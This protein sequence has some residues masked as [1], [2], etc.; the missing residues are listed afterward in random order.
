[1]SQP[2]LTQE[3]VQQHLL[4]AAYQAAQMVKKHDYA[5]LSALARRY[6]FEQKAE[7]RACGLSLN[8]VVLA[9][10]QALLERSTVRV[11]FICQ[12]CQRREQCSIW[13]YDYP[14]LSGNALYRL[15]GGK[16]IWVS[17]DLFCPQCQARTWVTSNRVKGKPSEQ[18][19]SALC[20]QATGPDCDCQCNGRNHGRAWLR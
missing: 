2:S 16:R 15:E 17:D 11:I 5:A 12:R 14:Y 20:Q 18:P 8:D 7:I 19:C 13:A 10:N 6:F 1:M 4:R 3:Q 9:F